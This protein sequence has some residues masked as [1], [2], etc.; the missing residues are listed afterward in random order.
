MYRYLVSEE[1]YLNTVKT[2][3]IDQRGPKKT[4]VLKLLLKTVVQGG[5]AAF[6]IIAYPDVQPWM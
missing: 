6:L 3:L 1:D 5:A 4:A 2:M